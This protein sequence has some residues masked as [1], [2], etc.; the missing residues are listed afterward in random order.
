MKFP[1]VGACK[2]VTLL[3]LLSSSALAQVTGGTFT[4][5]VLDS[6]NAAIRDAR[7]TAKNVANGVEAEVRSN[8]EGVYRMPPLVPGI[9]ILT[10]EKNDFRQMVFGPV[11]LE[12][13]QTV[14]VSF[15]LPV[16]STSD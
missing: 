6:S 5:S 9:Y 1:R 14:T 4:G 13:N 11:A 3:V 2:S 7:V 8:S 15:A 12:V 10:A 16:G